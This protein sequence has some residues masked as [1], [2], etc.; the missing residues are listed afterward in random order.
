MARLVGVMART[1]PDIAKKYALFF[2]SFMGVADQYEISENLIDDRHIAEIQFLKEKGLIIEF[3]DPKETKS[4]S[5][6]LDGFCIDI[7]RTDKSA[8]FRYFDSDKNEFKEEKFLLKDRNLDD[9]I[10]RLGSLWADKDMGLNA[11]PIYLRG[12]LLPYPEGIEGNTKKVDVTSIALTRMPEPDES[13][14]WEQILDYRSDPQ[15]NGKM[16]ALR[17]WMNKIVRDNLSQRE[18]EDELDWL[19]YDYERQI[20]LHRM[21][22]RTGV[23][24][25]IVTSIPDIIQKLIRVQWG[26]AAKTLFKL[27]RLKLELMEAEMKVPGSEVAY[28][29][30]TRRKFERQLIKR[31]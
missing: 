5:G 4:G 24:E 7:P 28:L 3:F 16:L 9:F 23:L 25:T 26:D 14:S 19:M 18:I 22:Y 31:S 1:L 13:V 20:K 2:D 15:S 10:A 30:E 11:C 27:T 12:G 29:V 17:K 21:K 8:G 6:V